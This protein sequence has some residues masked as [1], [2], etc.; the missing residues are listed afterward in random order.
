MSENFGLSTN[1]IYHCS[2]T[3]FN[4][5]RGTLE[6]KVFECNLFLTKVLYSDFD[7]FFRTLSKCFQSCCQN[8]ILRFQKKIL[9]SLFG[10]FAAFSPILSKSLSMFWQV[11][12]HNCSQNSIQHVQ[13]SNW[14]KKPLQFSF[15]FLLW[16]TFSW[17]FWQKNSRKVVKTE[18]YISGRNIKAL[19][20]CKASNF[21]FFFWLKAGK[22]QQFNRK[23]SAS[24]SSYLRCLRRN[25]LRKILSVEEFV[26]V[27]FI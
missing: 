2:G 16:V 1:E 7:L 15:F 21:A 11:K 19:F 13:R 25:N 6:G 22:F 8:C 3:A 4:T 18:Y 14:R 9:T 17:I 26:A 5:L 12:F 20:S 27:I 24:L 23:R 10:E